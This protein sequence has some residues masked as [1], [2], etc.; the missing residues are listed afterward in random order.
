MFFPYQDLTT[1]KSPIAFIFVSPDHVVFRPRLK[2]LF[3]NFFFT[4][5]NGKRYLFHA[6]KPVKWS[7]G[8]GGAREFHF[9]S[10]IGKNGNAFSPELLS[11]IDAYKIK[12]KVANMSETIAAVS[13]DM[14]TNFAN[15][16]KMTG[17]K[18]IADAVERKKLSKK[19]LTES[20]FEDLS[21]EL[22]ITISDFVM[23]SELNQKEKENI[24]STLAKQGLT[25]VTEPINTDILNDLKNYKSFDP[26]WITTLLNATQQTELEHKKLEARAS[27]GY[28]KLLLM[29]MLGGIISIMLITFVATSEINITLPEIGI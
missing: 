19:K 27:K 8:I 29:G 23:E 21:K 1:R 5:I 11:R 10:I 3:G 2:K 28:N 22:G 25:H 20:D 4:R 15:I 24:L 14:R 9:F 7:E 6:N 12:N 16:A 18:K 17:N 26:S 13:S